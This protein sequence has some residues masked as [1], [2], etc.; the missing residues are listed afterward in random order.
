MERKDNKVAEKVDDLCSDFS[1]EEQS[2]DPRGDL[3]TVEGS[4]GF[5]SD[6]DF[7]IDR[8]GKSPIAFKPFNLG[9]KISENVFY[10]VIKNG[11]YIYSKD[12]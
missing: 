11:I 6:S 10:I 3:G 2:K 4:I 7:D 5:I 1:V 9:V 8:L 12:L